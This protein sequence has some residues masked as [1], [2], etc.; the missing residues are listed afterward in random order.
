MFRAGRMRML[1]PLSALLATT[2]AQ[3]LPP[4]ALLQAGYPAGFR[5][6]IPDFPGCELFA[7]H[8]KLNSP[9][10]GEELGTLSGEVLRPQD[11]F[12][13]FQ[14]LNAVLTPG[15]IIHYWTTV[16]KDKIPYPKHNLT[17][18]VPEPDETVDLL[19]PVTLR[20]PFSRPTPMKMRDTEPTTPSEDATTPS[21]ESSEDATPPPSPDPAEPTE[22]TTTKPTTTTKKPTT[23]Q[24]PKTNKPTTKKPKTTPQNPAKQE[25]AE[26]EELTTPAS[27]FDKPITGEFPQEPPPLFPF[28]PPLFPTPPQPKPP[29]PSLFPTPKPM[30]PPIGPGFEICSNP[31]NFQEQLGESRTQRLERQVAK[32]QC[33][34]AMSQRAY[35]QLGNTVENELT[36]LKKLIYG[37]VG[38]MSRL[39]NV[40][41]S[42]AFG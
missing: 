9:F 28:F 29:K 14:D 37:M 22:K 5:A 24:K 19:S 34:L 42:A 40:I 20:P 41:R 18:T 11:G 26:P 21:T 31:W 7:F 15:D 4:E 25:E 13:I 39:E 6:F 30:M 32:L 3:W 1:L 16:V 2:A 38:R 35:N 23:T 33:E 36:D 8:G 27:P 17:W 12:W 10:L